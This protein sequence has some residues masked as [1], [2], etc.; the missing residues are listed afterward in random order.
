MV[1]SYKAV[2][3]DFL[4]DFRNISEKKVW[5][6]LRDAIEPYEARNFMVNFP[7]A[8]LFDAIEGSRT[9]GNRLVV[10]VSMVAENVDKIREDLIALGFPLETGDDWKGL[11]DWSK[12]PHLQIQISSPERIREAENPELLTFY[13]NQEKEFIYVSFLQE[14]GD[15]IEIG[16]D[17]GLAML[18]YLAENLLLFGRV[19]SRS[20]MDH[21]LGDSRWERGV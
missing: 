16:R 18:G 10:R 2:W 15:G 8:C 6:S 19:L 4:S 13:F 17:L 3:T 9:N 7:Y 1:E 11:R 20:E 5:E 12:K 21:I 14:I